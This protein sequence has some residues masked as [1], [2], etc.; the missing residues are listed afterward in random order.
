MRIS[1]IIRESHSARLRQKAFTNFHGAALEEAVA[2]WIEALQNNFEINRRAAVKIYFTPKKIRQL[3]PHYQ[4]PPFPL[5]C[6]CTASR[7]GFIAAI[8]TLRLKITSQTEEGSVVSS[9]KGS[10]RDR[11][12]Y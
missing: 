1:E 7:Y 8:V 6:L 10:T 12:E 11:K 4:G 2:P 3:P 5:T 9:A